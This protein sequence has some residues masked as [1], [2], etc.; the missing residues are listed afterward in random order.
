MIF[1]GVIVPGAPSGP[2]NQHAA[3]WPSARC[4][5]GGI[6]CL[7]ISCAFQQRSW[8]G[9]P[10]GGFA[11]GLV[12]G[13]ALVVR[14]VA[15]GRYELGEAVPVEAGVLL[16]LGLLLAGGTGVGALLLG[17]EVLQTAVLEGDVPVIGHV[18][19]VTSLI[20]DVGVYLIVIGLVLDILRSLGAELDRRRSVAVGAMSARE[21]VPS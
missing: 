16:G 14:Y 21:E 13:L 19:F 11:G 3:M 6:C 15:G 5:S 12:A 20:F 4:S 9:Q 10:G 2:G 17:G 8:N 1:A 18:K 7:Q